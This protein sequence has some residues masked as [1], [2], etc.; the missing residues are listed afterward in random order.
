MKSLKISKRLEAVAT[1]VRDGAVV[2]DIGTD[3][4]YIPIYLAQNNKSKK[5]LAS[6]INE[7][8]IA[9]A[10][11]NI[12][13]YGLNNLITTQIANGLDGIETFSPN[14]IIICGMGG[15]LISEII[16][17]SDY[18]KR[19]GIRL[20][21]Q[22]MTSVY[23]LRKYL[24]KGFFTVD[25]NIIFEDGKYYQIMCVTYD[26]IDRGYSDF[27]LEFGLKNIEKR[28]DVFVNF[29]N[30]TFVKKQK[31]LDGLKKGGC[32]TSALEEEIRELEKM[33]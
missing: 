20:I 12:S 25:E 33:L 27:Q 21:L 23:E 18:V 11:E 14:D 10:K 31:K 4:A 19:E 26:G 32:D 28:E 24:Q 9:R 17:K 30:F 16:E 8:P 5:I 3:H 13:L 7:G 1:Y 15:E 2:A 6:D 29:L 22:P